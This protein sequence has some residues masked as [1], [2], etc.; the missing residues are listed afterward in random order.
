M[1]RLVSLP[2]VSSFTPAG[3]T[4]V[5]FLTASISV[6]NVNGKVAIEWPQATSMADLSLERGSLSDEVFAQGKTQKVYI[7]RSNYSAFQDIL[8]R[9]IY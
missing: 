4:E 2:L 5:S 7:V 3:V 8:T 9:Q 1:S 6:D